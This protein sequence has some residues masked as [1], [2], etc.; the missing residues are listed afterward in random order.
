MRKTTEL[1]RVFCAIE[2]PHDVRARVAEHIA[3]LR[4]A[5][6]AARA[7]WARDEGL[8]ITLKFVGEIQPYKVP[9]VSTAAERSS[10]LVE[11]FSV[12]LDS[13]GTFPTR[14]TP[15]VLWI[16]AE[17]PSGNL[18]KLQQNLEDECASAGFA[19]NDRP[20]HPHLTIARQR[21]P[22]GARTPAVLPRETHFES[23]V[24]PATELVVI[25]SE[26]GYEGARYTAI[27]RHKLE[28]VSRN[29]FQS[30]R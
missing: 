14:G 10:H 4:A 26:L 30:Q 17:D 18:A 9:S 27:S 29:P 24:F 15:R 5:Q 16:G 28:V 11:P 6:P 1:W 22:Q 2:L 25:R 8:H 3:K 23:A 7:S 12:V 20:F 13:T 19:R 21:A